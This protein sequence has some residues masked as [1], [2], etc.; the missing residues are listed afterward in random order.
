M[1]YH[2]S[3]SYPIVIYSCSTWLPPKSGFLEAFEGPSNRSSSISNPWSGL[4]ME[5]CCSI[6]YELSRLITSALNF[7]CIEAVM[8]ATYMWIGQLRTWLESFRYVCNGRPC[9]T[10]A[11]DLKSPRMSSLPGKNRTFLNAGWGQWNLWWRI[12]WAELIR[13]NWASI[14]KDH[15]NAS[16]VGCIATN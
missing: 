10:F 3:D 4:N 5:S 16:W 7:R 13:S 6:S 8:W 12:R 9:L 2:S 14:W 15:K 1:Q 11:R